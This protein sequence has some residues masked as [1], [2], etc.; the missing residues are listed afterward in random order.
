VSS[1]FFWL[2][3]LLVLAL[4]KPVFRILIAMIG[5]KAI[6]AAALARQPDEI[7]L[8]RTGVTA[9]KKYDAVAKVSTVLASRGFEDAGVYSIAEMPGVTV[10][11]MAQ[12]SDGFY[13]AIYEHPL[14][15]VWF[16]VVSRFQD[17]TSATCTT[18]PPTALQPR[19]GH[20]SF[21]MRGADTAEVLDKAVALRPRRPLVDVSAAA[22]VGEFE[23]AYAEQMA[24]RKQAG[25]STGEVVG[26]AMRKV[27]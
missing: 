4:L 2:G 19:P 11:L 7:H 17:G 14:A 10:Q 25:I 9:W 26:T 16:D 27:A 15:G 24:Y 18:A 21:N 1:I 13:A 12:R 22:A 23:R 3:A 5:G 6:G 20:A 8:Q